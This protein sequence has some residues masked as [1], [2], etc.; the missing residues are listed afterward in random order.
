MGTASTDRFDCGVVYALAA[1]LRHPETRTIL[2]SIAGPEAFGCDDSRCL[3]M[4]IVR[5]RWG[6]V[7]MMIG[8]GKR[9]TRMGR[10]LGVVLASTV[11]GDDAVWAADLVR[12]QIRR[13]SE[14]IAA[15][16]LRWIA[17]RL[18]DRDYP[19]DRLED[20][21]RQAFRLVRE[22]VVSET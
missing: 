10:L 15:A 14:P 22:G 17:D 21:A 20:A 13:W 7:E 5:D 16:Q 6:G 19:V 11:P 4:A 2:T 1:L 9:H 3:A 12:L 8:T 18:G